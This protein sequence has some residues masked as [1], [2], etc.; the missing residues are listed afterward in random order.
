MLPNLKAVPYCCHQLLYSPRQGLA[1]SLVPCS[2]SAPMQVLERVVEQ[3]R[4]SDCLENVMTVISTRMRRNFR[5]LAS[6]A[7]PTLDKLSRSSNITKKLYAG[8][9]GLLCKVFQCITLHSSAEIALVRPYIPS[10][11]SGQAGQ[12]QRLSVLPARG[13]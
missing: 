2:Q 4:Q 9:D 12:W 1:T 3:S 6:S 5:A 8:A 11:I 7:A 13:T 10:V